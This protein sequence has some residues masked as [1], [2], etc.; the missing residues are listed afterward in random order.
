MKKKNRNSRRVLL[1]WLLTKLIDDEIAQTMSYQKAYPI[2]SPWIGIKF[3]SY[4]LCK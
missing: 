1:L 4:L 3:L 2:N